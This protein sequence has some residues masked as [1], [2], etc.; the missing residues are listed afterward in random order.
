MQTYLDLHRHAAVRA[1]LLGYPGLALRLMVAHAIG[2]SPLWRVSP[3]PQARATTLCA[4]AS[5]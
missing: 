5:S 3:D 1:A 4:R 2:G